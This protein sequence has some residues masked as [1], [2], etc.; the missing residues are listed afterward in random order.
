MKKLYFII[1]LLSCTLFAQTSM[2]VRGTS[3]MYVKDSYVFVKDGINLQ[4]ANNFIYL[5]NEGQ[6]L[7][8]RVGANANN[9]LGRI[10]I[11]QEGT[12]GHFAYNYWCA[13]VG[14]TTATPTIGDFGITMAHRP[15]TNIA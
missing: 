10:S 8:G 11:F 9:G 3:F 4:T 5:R 14:N 2:T 12:S 7:Q 13:P 15:T 6:L 1:G